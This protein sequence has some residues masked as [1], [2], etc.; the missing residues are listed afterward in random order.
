MRR[1][2]FWCAQDED[3]SVP[4]TFNARLTRG[5]SPQYISMI[6]RLGDFTEPPRQVADDACVNSPMI[7]EKVKED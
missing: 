1:S 6:N 5:D 4:V 7:W 3:K 2:M